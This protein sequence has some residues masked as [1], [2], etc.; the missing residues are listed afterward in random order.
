V[1]GRRPA[2]PWAIGLAIAMPAAGVAQHAVTS[3]AGGGPTAVPARS[4]SVGHP[5]AVTL[6]KAGNIYIA[7]SAENRVYKVSISGMLT[8]IAGNGGSGAFST[9]LAS[10]GLGSSFQPTAVQLA[11]P[12]S[13][14]VDTEG[15]V[16]IA[17]GEPGSSALFEIGAGTGL[18]RQVYPIASYGGVYDTDQVFIDGFGRV[19]IVESE[20]CEVLELSATEPI[21]SRIAGN[22]SCGYSGDGGAAKSA[23]LDEPQGIFVD[24]S[25]NVF[26]A[27]AGNNAIREVNAETGVITTTAGNGAPGNGANGAAATGSVLYA[28]QGVW[29]D[30]LG[31][32]FIADTG[33]NAIREVTSGQIYT[34]AG[35]GTAGYL[36]DGGA[37]TAA[38]LNMPTGLAMDANRNLFIAD[39]SNCLVREVTASNQRIRTFA[40]NGFESYSGDGGLAANAQLNNPAGV[41]IDAAGDIFIADELNNA[42][43]EIA[44][45]TGKIATI[46]G[47]GTKGYTGNGGPA[48]EAQLNAPQS[49]FADADGNVFIADSGNNVVREVRTATGTIVTFAG[50]G[51]AG[52]R[53]DGGA[54]TSAEL[55]GP[56]TVF[57]DSSGNI[58]IADFNN[59]AVRE[60]SGTDGKI[61]T[62]TGKGTWGYS[63]DQGP[64]ANAQL[65][66]P[67]ALYV[68]MSGNLFVADTYNN[69][70]REVTASDGK[71]STVAGNGTPGSEGDGGP[72]ASA[73]LSLPAGVFADG[74]GNL[75]IVQDYDSAF[76]TGFDG[77][78]EV[79]AKTNL[80]STLAGTSLYQGYINSSSGT[81]AQFDV[82]LGLA[83][84][85]QGNLFV[86]DSANQRI[87]KIAG[88][89]EAS[90][91][92]QVPPPTFVPAAGVY[93][94]AQPVTLHD[95]VTGA[96]IY[97]TTDGKSPAT[98]STRYRSPIA[99]SSNVTIAAVAAAPGE[100]LSPVAEARYAI[101][102]AAPAPVFSPPPG[103]YVGAQTV[104]LTTGVGGATIHYT[105]NGKTPTA[106][107]PV[108]AGPIAVSSSITLK[109]VAVAKG[110]KSNIAGGGKYSIESQVA[111][112]TFTPQPRGYWTAQTVTITDVTDGA[113]I[114]YTLDGTQPSTKSA[115]YAGAAIPVTKTATINAI[116]VSNGVSS[117]VA[118]ALFTINDETLVEERALAQQGI[119]IG[120]A[121]QTFFSQISLAEN[122]LLYDN[123]GQCG[124]ADSSF[125]PLTPSGHLGG[126][127]PWSPASP[128]APGYATI[129]Y[130][131]QCK[132]PWTQASLYDWTLQ[133]NDS[134]G[135]LNGTTSETERL[136]GPNG[137]PLGTM[138]VNESIG[139]SGSANDIGAA[140]FGTG[141][142]TPVSA[143]TVAQ[144]GFSCSIDLVAFLYEDSPATC[145]GAIAQDFKNLGM[146]LGFTLPLTF[147][148]VIAPGIAWTGSEFVAVGASGEVFTS[149]DGR[150]WTDRS[151][152]TASN[153]RGVAPSAGELI[154]VGTGGTIVTSTNGG[155]SWAAQI[156]GT[157]ANFA[158]VTWSGSQYV[159]VGASGLNGAIYTSPDGSSWTS[160]Y[161]EPG[162]MLLRGIVWPGS[163]F[164]AVGQGQDGGGAIL[165]SSDGVTWTQN[166][167]ATAQYPLEAIAASGSQFV[168]VG[169]GD[170]E[171][172]STE[173]L[174]S[175]D[176]VTWTAQTVGGFGANLYAITWSPQKKLFVAVGE[177]GSIVTSPDG[178]IWSMQTSH[179][180]FDLKSV[181]WS[182]SLFAAI[183]AGNSLVTSPD[184][185]NWTAI[186][187]LPGYGEL[188]R[189]SSNGSSVVSGPLGGLEV[190][191]PA[192]QTVDV[193]GGSFYGTASLNGYAGDLA[194][195][196]PAPTG[197]T[198]TDAAHRQQLQIVLGNNTSRIF[199]GSITQISS[200]K[201]LA[202]F[203]VDRSGTGSITYSDKSK[204][205]I[206]NW[207]LSE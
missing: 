130:D 42:V 145:S 63:G 75:F 81:S 44:A 108:Y 131:G 134:A 149:P 37:A 205:A 98:S 84:D 1:A 141:T 195:F 68:D 176:G 51:T 106:S 159:A 38:E 204:T 118:N 32:I 102:T 48:V 196:T 164:A 25:G 133:S 55:D 143:G 97:F 129:Y 31:D 59:N 74:D 179:T 127:M 77:I 194:I 69:V 35:N 13:V 9:N 144:L 11:N 175:P 88:A 163:L 110:F 5:S 117:S 206:T 49:V 91:S 201:T 148:P 200:G 160:R 153:L 52:Y 132:Q 56:A 172:G 181:A 34:V 24:A 112:P 40:G 65:W 45:S 96:A 28:P 189:L 125:F 126:I 156:S 193:T 46:A 135:T 115:K 147:S 140:T 18:I 78:R 116:A 73:Q 107:S 79:A 70:I 93:P 8:V 161:S 57:A 128:Y 14:A 182:G 4:A 92:L 58:F 173:V 122:M 151:S 170:G 89:E 162:I 158:A 101:T 94:T 186:T 12:K 192:P 139:L 3:V 30:N 165:T 197:W 15:D 103:R 124:D 16:Y 85:R 199:S 152:G 61:R 119:G 207:L 20:Y 19:F 33:N 23:Q 187:S 180:A 2:I 82:P 146:S 142:F 47:N 169:D 123:S 198:V 109:A 76:Y 166:T 120:L 99:V 21:G 183:G 121:M 43:R 66:G 26:I 185:V 138:K 67:S 150:A 167:T 137:L 90:A 154:A 53:G 54:A 10:S 178:V 203:T 111:T 80:I 136:F 188:V 113:V 64:A 184:G 157:G 71:I 27:D 105:T 22:G 100:T 6:D 17:A 202:T 62:I 60:V 50:T 190:T 171:S 72:A 168:A 104:T 174:T 7:D 177:A 29:V 41:F 114:Y 36:G 155:T 191:T 87:R 95:A 83:G 39:E 86:A